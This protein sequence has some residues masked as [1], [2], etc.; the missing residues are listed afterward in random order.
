MLDD[1]NT[2]VIECRFED[3]SKIEALLLSLAGKLRS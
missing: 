1:V 2:G 3:W